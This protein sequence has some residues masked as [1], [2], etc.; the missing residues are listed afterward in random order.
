MTR[1]PRAGAIFLLGRAVGIAEN[2]SQKAAALL[3]THQ[4]GQQ[5]SFR[6]DARR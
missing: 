5:R 2:D 6:D 1:R 3:A 4:A